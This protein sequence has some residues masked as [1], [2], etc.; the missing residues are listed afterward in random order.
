MKMAFIHSNSFSKQKE[1]RERGANM[2]KRRQWR[3]WYM[4]K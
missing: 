1:K 4:K 3:K 2:R